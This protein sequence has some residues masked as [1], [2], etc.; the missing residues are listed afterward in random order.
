ML[1][2]MSNEPVVDLASS[3]HGE[4]QS[5]DIYDIDSLVILLG[6]SEHFCQHHCSC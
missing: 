5:S 2:C 4:L 6:L 3:Y 1:K